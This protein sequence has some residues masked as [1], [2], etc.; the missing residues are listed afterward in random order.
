MKVKILRIGYLVVLLVDKFAILEIWM[1]LKKLEMFLLRILE[2]RIVAVGD[3][4]GDVDVAAVVV[5]V[6]AVAVAVVL[7]VI[8]LVVVTIQVLVMQQMLIY[9]YLTLILMNL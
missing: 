6:A 4:V 3:V 9:L 2:M 7:V 8:F 5:V 1:D